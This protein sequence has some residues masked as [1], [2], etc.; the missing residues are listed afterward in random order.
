MPVFNGLP[1]ADTIQGSATE[2]TIFGNAGDDLLSGEGLDDSILGGAGDDTIYGDV[3]V[4]TAPGVDASPI[5]LSIGN[6]VSDSSSGN[7]N[8]QVNDVAIY[9]DVAELADGTLVSARLILTGTTNPNLNID[10]SGANGAEI[11]LNSGSGRVPAGAEASFRMEFFDPATGDPIALN[12]VATFNDLDRN[13]VGDQEAVTLDTASFTNY[14]VAPVS[15]LAVTNAAG[16]VTASGTEQNSPADTDAWFSAGFENREFIEFTLEAR[17]SPSGFTMSGDL[18]PDAVVTEIEAGD[19]TILGGAGNDVIL[20]QGGDDS[21]VAGS[22]DDSIEGGDGM[23]AIVG[24]TGN[25][26]LSGGNNSD[27]FTFDGAGDH[28]IVGGED[29]DGSDIDVID[30]SGINARVIQGGAENGIIEFLDAGGAVI[31]TAT[32][33]QIEQVICFT[34]EAN[35]MTP[36]GPRRADSLQI[37]DKVI[38][39]DNGPQEL[40][41]IGQKTLNVGN[42]IANPDLAPVTI[43]AGALGNGLPERT[44]FLSPNHRV[45]M[46]GEMNRIL[47]DTPEVLLAAKHLVGRPGITQKVPNSVTYLHMMF[48]NHE[49]IMSEGAWSESFQP[50]THALQGVES[51]QRDELFSIFPELKTAK[52]LQDYS[53]ARRSLKGFESE[54]LVAEL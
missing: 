46:Q 53:A 27:I 38:T 15:S 49:V 19:D 28:V 10:M 45:L 40:A 48:E 1:G 26:T 24:G 13:G 29:A 4:G 35:I 47:F 34:P 30:L 3:G 11:L 5:D 6:L 36:R 51:S 33:S 37:G 21:L 16:S 42:M 31:N 18:I 23:D 52:G 8:A 14:A 7:N 9:S 22:G 50:A 39:R 12:S 17:S 43:A 41:W 20:G 32:Y 44:L 2:D 25:D 54:I